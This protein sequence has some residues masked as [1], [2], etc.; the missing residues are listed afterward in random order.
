M[1]MSAPIKVKSK[2]VHVLE[3][4]VVAAGR[5]VFDHT[6]ADPWHKNTKAN[7]AVFSYKEDFQNLWGLSPDVGGLD[8][9]AKGLAESHANSEYTIAVVWDGIPVQAGGVSSSSVIAV[10]QYVSPYDWAVALTFAIYKQSSG[11]PKLRFLI[12]DVAATGKYFLQ[13]SLFAFHNV[14]P[15]IQDY[16]VT[17]TGEPW[18]AE[19]G[20]ADMERNELTYAMLRQAVPQNRQDA[21]RLIQDICQPEC[22][23]TTFS[24][25]DNCHDHF[26]AIKE[27]WRQQFLKAGDRHTVGNL[28]GPFILANGLP[29]EQRIQANEL[30]KEDSLLRKALVQVLK[31]LGMF[32]TDK[33]SGEDK[34]RTGGVV[35]NEVRLDSDGGVFGRRKGV[36]FLLVDDQFSLGYHHIVALTLLK[37]QYEPKEAVVNSEGEWSYTK[38]ALAE[39]KCVS[40]EKVIF[41]RLN[42]VSPVLDW[43]LPRKLE[44]PDRN[45]NACDVL[46]LDLRLWLES[47]TRKK[48]MTELVR[49]CDRLKSQ[50]INDEGFKQALA[51]AK[52]CVAG[53]VVSEIQM[54]VL[55]PL[56]ISHYDPSLPIVLFSSTHQRDVTELLAHRPNIITKFAKPILTGYGEVQRPSME[57]VKLTCA[58]N[59]AINLHE[60]RGVWER[61]PAIAWNDCARPWF[62]LGSDP[63]NRPGGTIVQP[64]IEGDRLKKF[65]AYCYEHYLQG[66]AYY[67]FASAPFE[68]IEGVLPNLLT[69]PALDDAFRLDDTIRNQPGFALKNM[70]HR[71]AHG[72]AGRPRYEKESEEWRMATILEF[73]IWLDF[74]R[75][76]QLTDNAASQLV[77]KSELEGWQNTT[78][79]NMKSQYAN[80]LGGLINRTDPPNI[81]DLTS[82]EGLPWRLYVTYA[83]VFALLNSYKGAT[84][85]FRCSNE[86]KL[87]L[88]ELC[89]LN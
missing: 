68:F 37:N 57:I 53:E 87:I 70:R 60:A 83:A 38:N 71:K 62:T 86:T 80:S 25:I 18:L 40:S 43:A 31:Q 3:A 88:R 42:S 33:F 7:F 72:Y 55:L 49:I 11:K 48:F 32:D 54:L 24:E 67:D 61:L 26:D 14:F 6:S 59:K 5:V 82:I 46:I 76:E 75:D 13:K 51:A 35:A 47:K 20:L 1:N 28:I 9:I 30:I 41:D 78:W 4:I 27:S 89:L 8:G 84:P 16:Q 19:S 56:L 64:R 44:I 77:L 34:S 85:K 45:N 74:I 15:W 23:L 29:D 21:E 12:L 66:E 63:Y 52:E 79:S 69:D 50:G 10:S 2:I 22:V 36:R 17:L 65:F 58:L 81:R 73:Q 39:L